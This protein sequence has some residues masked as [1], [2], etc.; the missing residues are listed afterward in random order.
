VLW[1]RL[2]SF[3]VTPL[4]FPARSFL[5]FFN[6]YPSSYSKFCPDY[7]EEK[8]LLI[9][10]SLS[11][12]RYQECSKDTNFTQEEEINLEALLSNEVCVVNYVLN[13]YKWLK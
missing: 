10:T 13:L 4:I 9:K 3:S 8:E 11:R 5:G 7:V 1:R 12:R 6:G 2:G